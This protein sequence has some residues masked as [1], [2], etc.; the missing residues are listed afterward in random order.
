MQNRMR[1][2]VHNRADKNRTEER[3]GEKGEMIHGTLF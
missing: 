1:P 2:F 3:K